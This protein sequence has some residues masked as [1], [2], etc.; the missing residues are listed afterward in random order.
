MHFIAEHYFRAAL[1]RIE[2]AR[3]LYTAERY[4][5]SL[6]V[7]G[8]AAECIFRA[9]YWR[10]NPVF[11]ARHDLLHLFKLSG[12]GMAHQQRLLDRGVDALQARQ[13]MIELAAAR[14]TL[15]RL[16]NNDYRFAPEA[17]LRGRL[18]KL[19]VL[20]RSAGNQLKPVA[21]SLYNAAKTL[22]DTGIVL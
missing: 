8:L 19:G 15:V 16:W 13:A 7:S 17:Q 1:E 11:D 18:R 20:G 14:D 6:Y 5:L 2:E 12:I 9:F 22:I 21:I 10:R 3:V 4:G